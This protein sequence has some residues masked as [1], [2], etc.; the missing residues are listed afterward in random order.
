MA[1]LNILELA[2]Q[3]A[4][5]E[6]RL[7][8]YLRAL[9]RADERITG[10]A[11]RYTY[12][13]QLTAPLSGEHRQRLEALLLSGAEPAALK[14]K[15]ARLYVAP[16]P[17]TV[18]PWSSKATDIARACDLDEVRRIERGTCYA[19]TS[20]TGANE[21]SLL[22]LAP[23]L[24]DRMTETVLCA[25]D[26][27]RQLFDQHAPAPLGVV[28]LGGDAEAALSVANRTLGLALSDD[29]VRYLATNYRL[30]GRDPTDAELMMFA[31]ANSEH[32]RHKIFNADWVIDGEAMDRRLFGMIRATT[33]ANP[34][35]V[36]SAYSDNA[37]VLE[38][39]ASRRL[40]PDSDSREYRYADEAV[41]ILMKVET[42]NH[43]TAISPFPGA[44]TG[45]GGEIRDEGATGLG[46]R[47]KAGLTGLGF[48]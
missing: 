6:F 12:W 41:H 40:M 24:H 31:Q 34:N 13:I 21:S 32:C 1:S 48:I 4:L 43:P 19:I 2:G 15:T 20:R 16:R 29:E 30:L 42:H 35:G 9:K 25:G 5:S 22:H 11:A 3:A 27:A 37:A 26:E 39:P 36:L 46:A 10:L 23:L 7:A 17:G 14:S 45:A 8:K 28:P 38:G 44:A 18:S 33:E 47:P